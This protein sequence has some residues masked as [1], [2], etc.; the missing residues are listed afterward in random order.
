M[1]YFGQINH[2]NL[3]IGQIISIIS[4]TT[5]TNKRL[6]QYSQCNHFITPHLFHSKYL[7]FYGR[8]GVLSCPSGSAL[9]ARM[10]EALCFGETILQLPADLQ[11]IWSLEKGLRW[12][13]DFT[14]I[15]PRRT[16]ST[17]RRT[18][19][20]RANDHGSNLLFALFFLFRACAVRGWTIALVMVTSSYFPRYHMSNDA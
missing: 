10:R 8:H 19:T 20:R 11:E 7:T 5:W 17:V 13:Y 15:G 2:C 1:S 14:K 4:I 16:V 3:Q 12:I 6:G 9:A 18:F